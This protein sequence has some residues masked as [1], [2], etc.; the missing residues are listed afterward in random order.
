VERG[1]LSWGPDTGTRLTIADRDPAIRIIWN[2]A[3]SRFPTSQ[4]CLDCGETLTIAQRREC[5]K[6]RVLFVASIEHGEFLGGNS[7]T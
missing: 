7:G 4:S 5:S 2:L 6:R 1:F 3:P